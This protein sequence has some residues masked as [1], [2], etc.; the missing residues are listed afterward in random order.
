MTNAMQ[1]L[2]VWQERFNSPSGSALGFF[3][4]STSIGSVIPLLTLNWLGDYM[5]RRWPT[6]FG[7]VVVAVGAVIQTC[8]TSLNM[9]IGGKIVLGFGC[10]LVQMGAPVLVAEL[11]HPKE[12][13]RVTS[14]Y[15]T[16][17]LL[18]YV[19]GAWLAFGCIHMN[20]PWQ[21]KFP[22]LLQA[23]PSVYQL[24][25]I[26]F[27]PESPRWLIAH[28]REDEALR[29]LHKYHGDG[30][31]N[32]KLVEVEYA[33]IK[34]ALR[35]ER[36]N[37][38]SWKDMFAS[39][40]NRRRL[41]IV[42][43]VA[44]FAQSCGNLLISNFL[45]QILKDTGVSQSLPTTNPTLTSHQIESTRDSTLINGMNT[46]WAWLLALGVAATFDKVR[47]RTFFLIGTGGGF[48]VFIVWTIA[49]QQYVERGSLPAGRLVIACIFLF[50]G[51]YSL[52]WLNMVA[53]YPIEL[54][55]YQHRA[56][57]WSYVL[58]VMFAT[59]IFGNYVNPVALEAIG[60]K[61][62]IYYCVWD[63]VIVVV[64]YFFFPETSGLTLEESSMLLDDKDEV[65]RLK[66]MA[67]RV[68][69]GQ[70][71]KGGVVVVDDVEKV[72]INAE[73]ST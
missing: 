58:L 18:G 24:S 25:L 33:E 67:E 36:E 15:N 47:R 42:T 29:I 57:T 55:H 71:E 65:R 5:G 59:Q 41:F 52:A 17:V 23:A 37:T 46:L 22:T 10:S 14:F 2:P 26:F 32:S 70:D 9:Y 16:S 39:K 6:A 43:C 1:L 60:W 69:G 72:S 51:L 12:R 61:W 13:V 20:G 31:P 63:A 64:V 56:Q 27:S 21:W 34:E 66:E 35:L 48:L 8:A 44:I 19:V 49:S 28:D 4:A 68:K 38:A 3:G 73:K 45:P 62:Y 30:D 7:A 50:Q 54:V 11:S 40:A 53:C